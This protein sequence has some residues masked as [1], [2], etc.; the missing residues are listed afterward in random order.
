MIHVICG[1]MFARKSEHER[2]IVE[3]YTYRKRHVWLLRPERDTRP[4]VSTHGGFV[5]KSGPFLEIAREVR[6][7]RYYPRAPAGTALVVFTEAQ[8]F[9]DGLIHW[10]KAHDA[11]GI[12]VLVTCLDRDYRGEAFG[13]IKELLFVAHKVTKRTAVCVRCGLDA[14]RTQRIVKSDDLILIG[15]GESY[16]ARCERCHVA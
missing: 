2:E 10:V 9:D 8:L 11:L 7:S 14:T 1:P 4:E 5:L 12:D 16:E 15:A 3:N 13:E 6:G